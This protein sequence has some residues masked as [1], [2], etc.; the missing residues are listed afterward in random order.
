MSNSS[1]ILSLQPLLGDDGLLRV[2]GRLQHVKTD[3][4]HPIILNQKYPLVK[5]IV[6][7]LHLDNMLVLKPCSRL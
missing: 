7:Q 1:S 4:R 2:G 6:T 3:N 5:L